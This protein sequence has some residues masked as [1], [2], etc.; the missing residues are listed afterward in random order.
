MKKN[1]QKYLEVKKKY[2]PL[3]SQT[4]TKGLRI[5]NET[6]KQKFFENIGNSAK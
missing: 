2:L 3:H 1:F 4:E 6:E 5:G